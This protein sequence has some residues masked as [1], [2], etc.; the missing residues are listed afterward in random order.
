MDASSGLDAL[1]IMGRSPA[2]ALLIEAHVPDINGLEV[3]RRVRGSGAEA[4]MIP[5]V[6]IAPPAL[7]SSE[8]GRKLDSAADICLTEPV[9]ADVLLAALG[10]LVRA[11][12]AERAAAKALDRERVARVLA[13]EANALKNDFIATLSHELRTPLNALLGSVWQLRH[14]ATD[15][16]AR[17]R[18]LDRIERSASAQARLINDLLDLSG[19][20]KGTLILTLH[21]TDLAGVL[22]GSLDAVLP[23]AQHKR[24]RIEATLVDA[25][26]IADP[27]RL[28]QVFVN[29]L[30]NA[31]QFTPEA[32]RITVESRVDGGMVHV[33][34]SDSG[35][36]IAAGVLPL[37]FDQFRQ[38]E[39]GM[40]RKPGGLGL[41]LVVV[42]QLMDLHAGHVSVSSGGAGRGASFDVRLPV[43][44]DGMTPG[45]RALDALRVRV[46]A[47]GLPAAVRRTLL[48]AGA[49]VVDADV[50]DGV[51]E[52]G[53]AGPVD[54][55]VRARRAVGDAPLR[56]RERG[57][58]PP[59]LQVTPDESP[60]SV[61]RRVSRLTRQ[62]SA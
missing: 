51:H 23:A 35:A 31:V 49:H 61:V 16:A 30:T 40:S 45:V 53:A 36:G 52:T 47:D 48:A 20:A 43:E 50:P 55:V 28:H 44:S 9:D 10:A 8:P 6:L 33:R 38:G 13:D 56:S 14:S 57:L 46:V 32:G 29:L 58:A 25:L 39:G 24:V 21:A 7:S 11:R 2:D 42:K 27:D 34:V 54:V 17:A 62:A 1:R 41:G 19:I 26:V 15:E 5:I 59:V 37:V 12:R 60:A 3:I 18:A 22:R 4:S